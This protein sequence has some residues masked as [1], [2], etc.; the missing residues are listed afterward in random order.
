MLYLLSAE[1]VNRDTQISG[2]KFLISIVT[3][4]TP[5]YSVYL[6][7]FCSRCHLIEIRMPLSG[8]LPKEFQNIS[9]KVQSNANIW[10]D[11]YHRIEKTRQNFIY[12]GP[13]RAKA[14][15]TRC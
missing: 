15:I 8:I 10:V 4:L 9:L 6:S 5:D 13:V 3:S 14:L 2:Y 11:D 12:N 7:F 1:I